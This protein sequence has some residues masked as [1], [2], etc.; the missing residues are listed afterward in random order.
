MSKYHFDISNLG[1]SLF[2]ILP[3]S[4]FYFW[5]ITREE[6]GRRNPKREERERKKEQKNIKEMTKNFFF[7]YFS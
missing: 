6:W 7:L 3:G 1:S 4:N 5:L 2:F